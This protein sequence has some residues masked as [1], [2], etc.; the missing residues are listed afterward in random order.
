M[1][2]EAQAGN[3]KV[4]SYGDNLLRRGDVELLQGP[5]WLN[6]QII[7]FYFDYLRLERFAKEHD[8]V[9]FVGGAMTFLLNQPAGCIHRTY[10]MAKVRFSLKWLCTTA[11]RYRRTF[12]HCGA[13][14][15]SLSCLL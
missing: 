15:E 6:D 13:V 5:H 10:S 12:R 9:L 2:R 11:N 8:D 7:T 14:G 4:L 3:D 1:R